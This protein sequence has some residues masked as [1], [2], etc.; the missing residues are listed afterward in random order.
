M[1]LARAAG[2]IV[3]FSS[4]VSRSRRQATNE[5]FVALAILVGPLA[6]PIRWLCQWLR[7]SG[8]RVMSDANEVGECHNPDCRR[9]FAPA[10]DGPAFHCSTKCADGR[11]SR[12]MVRATF[13]ACAHRGQVKPRAE[14]I[15]TL[16]DA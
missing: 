3:T 6:W 13:N 1:A 5:E 7:S 16:I 11:L 10:E 2:V 15:R 12:R 4:K 9:E 8:P 14:T